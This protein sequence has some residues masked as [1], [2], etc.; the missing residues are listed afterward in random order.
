MSKIKSFSL[1]VLLLTAVFT[2]S[3]SNNDDGDGSSSSVGGVSSSSGGDGVYGTPVTYG[4]ETYETVVIGTQTWF[5]RNLNYNP[6]AGNSWCYGDEEYYDPEDAL[7]DSEIQANCVK[8]GRLY[9]WATAM[10]VCPSSFHLPTNADWN[11]LIN[12]AGE[13]LTAGIKLKATEGWMSYE[14]EGGNGTNDYG[15]SALPGGCRATTDPYG[16][17]LE[18]GYGGHWWSAD[19]YDS[20]SDAAYYQGISLFEYTHQSYRGKGFGFSVRCLKD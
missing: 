4:N 17:C 6:S 3:C 8:Y 2:F 15:F 13:Y 11:K 20:D 5:K 16:G 14:G 12:Y 7:T 18:V 9:D 10:T 1:V 19:E